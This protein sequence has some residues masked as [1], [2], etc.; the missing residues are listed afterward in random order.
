LSEEETSSVTYA[1]TALVDLVRNGVGDRSRLVRRLEAIKKDS[2]YPH[3]LR[4]SCHKALKA[5]G[6]RS[7]YPIPKLR[8][9]LRGVKTIGNVVEY[10]LSLLGWN[11]V[12]FLL[13][14]L[15]IL[16]IYRFLSPKLLRFTIYGWTTCLVAIA[17]FHPDHS[18]ILSPILWIKRIVMLILGIFEQPFTIIKAIEAGFKEQSSLWDQIKYMISLSFGVFVYAYLII[19]ALKY[20]PNNMLLNLAWIFVCLWSMAFAVI[21][22]ISELWS[23]NIAMFFL[24]LFLSPMGVFMSLSDFVANY[25]S[26]SGHLWIQ[27]QVSRWQER[28]KT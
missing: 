12:M 4:A 1:T 7:I 3:S 25:W 17:S 16:Y 14:P 20:V 28:R 2:R 23:V 15:S 19:L 13:T 11:I 9:L 22:S 6:V 27:K 8:D 26:R 5:L 24:A 18:L 21:R 10:S